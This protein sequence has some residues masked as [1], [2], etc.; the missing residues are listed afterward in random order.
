MLSMRTAQGYLV[1]LDP[2]EEV[3]STLA[4]FCARE[5]VG[6]ASLAGIGAVRDAE[7]GYFEGARREYLR[8]ELPGEHELCSFSG[9]LTWRDGEPF[10]HAHVVLAGADFV[11]LAGHLFRA[12]ISA[13]GEF[14]IGKGG[15]KV[16]RELDAAT[17]LKLIAGEE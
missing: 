12:T 5:G 15:V 11:P 13:T 3:L 4:A 14:W 16:V 8:R 7:L 17:G 10:V 2:G 1:R 9:N 6:S